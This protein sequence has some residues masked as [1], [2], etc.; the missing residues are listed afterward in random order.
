[1]RPASRSHSAT[2]WGRWRDST[3]VGVCGET[4]LVERGEQRRAKLAGR[5][6]RALEVIGAIHDDADAARPHVGRVEVG[7]DEYRLVGSEAE[8]CRHQHERIRDRPVL[9]RRLEATEGRE[10]LRMRQH[11]LRATGGNERGAE[12]VEAH[13]ASLAE[14]RFSSKGACVLWEAIV[15]SA[16]GGPFSPAIVAEGRFVFVAG[17]GPLK[18]GTYVEGSIED[19]TRLTLENVGRLLE[20]AGSGFEHVVR[21]GVWLVDLADFAGMNGVYQSFFPEPGPHAQRSAPT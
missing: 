17:Q 10:R 18:D 11:R 20:Q 9:V 16:V 13:L 2:T 4:G 5:I 19:E 1:M 8:Q 14:S 6:G 12:V 3:P 7:D 15:G 21:C